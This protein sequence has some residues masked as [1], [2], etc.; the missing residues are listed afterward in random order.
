MGHFALQFAH[1]FGAYVIT[2]VS[3]RNTD[4]LVN[5]GANKVIDYTVTGFNEAVR[6]VD[7]AIDLIGDARHGDGA[8]SL[9]VL[10]RGGPIVH[11]AS[12]P[13]PTFASDAARG[14]ANDAT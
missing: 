10:R 14:G 13:W 4:F 1:H 2:T 8:R 11:V 5:L 12:G 9:S 3:A 6:N 7:G